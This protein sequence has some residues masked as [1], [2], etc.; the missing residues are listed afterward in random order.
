[1]SNKWSTFSQTLPSIN[2]VEVN[3][4]YVNNGQFATNNNGGIL[5]SKLFSALPSEVNYVERS[6][7]AA[8]IDSN[9]NYIPPG[10]VTF[11]VDESG[12]FLVTEAGNFIIVT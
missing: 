10:G 5:V 8:F 6:V 1:M 11:L 9:G 3:M 2:C 7:V 12:N 4:G